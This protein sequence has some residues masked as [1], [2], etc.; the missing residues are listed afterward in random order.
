MKIPED[1]LLAA[2]AEVL[3]GEPHEVEPLAKAV[4]AL[5]NAQRAGNDFFDRPSGD[6][7][8]ALLKRHSSRF[9]I[10]DRQHLPTVVWLVDLERPAPF[11]ARGSATP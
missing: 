9:A 1:V 5:T 7:L 4:A 6:E 10:H 11:P 2:C 8:L 3:Y